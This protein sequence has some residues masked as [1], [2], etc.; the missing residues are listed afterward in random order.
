VF[1]CAGPCGAGAVRR[2]NGKTWRVSHYCGLLNPLLVAI[3]LHQ[4]RRHENNCKNTVHAA[5]EKTPRGNTSAILNL[6]V[7][8]KGANKI[9]LIK[10]NSRHKN[11]YVSFD[12]KNEVFLKGCAIYF[13]IAHRLALI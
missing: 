3:F 4:Q 7:S 13:N 11:S 12:F 1:V 2:C 6:C 10:N 8:L 5:A 9:L